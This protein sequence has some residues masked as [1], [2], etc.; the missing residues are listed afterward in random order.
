MNCYLDSLDPSVREKVIEMQSETKFKFGYGAVLQ[1][2]NIIKFPCVIAG[3]KCEIQ[4]DVVSCDIPLVLSKDSMKKAKVKLDLEN[5]YASIFGTDVQ[6]QSTSSGHY[7]VPIKQI[8]VSVDDTRSALVASKE[9]EIS[10]VIQ[11]LHKQFAHPSAK[12]L[13]SLL[14]DAGGYTDEHM[15]CVD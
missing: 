2:K 9:T 6:L 14:Q 12:R 13:K 3:T 8:N 10:D 1:S 4:T 7:C 11:K 5:D 15:V